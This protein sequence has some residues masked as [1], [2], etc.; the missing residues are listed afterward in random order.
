MLFEF[1]ASDIE[2]VSLAETAKAPVSIS[3]T[4]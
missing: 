2:S 1:I 3:V 4:P